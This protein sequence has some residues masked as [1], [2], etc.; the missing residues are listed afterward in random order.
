MKKY[1][2]EIENWSNIVVFEEIRD[3]WT[4]SNEYG[5]WFTTDQADFDWWS[6]IANAI[7]F[8]NDNDID[9]D[10]NELADY[11]TIAKENGFEG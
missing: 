3:S 10:V 2:T 4:E 6:Q 1:S 5:V 9:A 8:I 11:I 7:E